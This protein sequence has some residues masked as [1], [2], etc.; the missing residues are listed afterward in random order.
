MI[1]HFSGQHFSGQ[2]DKHDCA[3][4]LYRQVKSF[5][6]EV[7]VRKVMSILVSLVDIN[8]TCS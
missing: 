4:A 8:L 5:T 2:Q 3:N 6:C 1:M 7:I